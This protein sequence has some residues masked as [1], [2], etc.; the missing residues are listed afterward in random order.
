MNEI[1]L[2][3]RASTQFNNF[4]MDQTLSE[5]VE[6][7][8]MPHAKRREREEDGAWYEAEAKGAL[9]RKAIRAITPSDVEDL[10]TQLVCGSGNVNLLT[11]TKQIKVVKRILDLAVDRGLIEKNPAAG[12]L[13]RILDLESGRYN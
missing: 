11:A 12:Q 1:Q 9:G 7:T 3:N 6:G 8:Y 4:C 10:Y 5:F 2:N 13:R